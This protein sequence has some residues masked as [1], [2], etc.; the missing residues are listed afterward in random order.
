MNSDKNYSKTAFP[1][2]EPIRRT[3]TQ[4][5]ILTPPPERR[6]HPAAPVRLAGL[7]DESGVPLG[8]A[9]RLCGGVRIPRPRRCI[10][11]APLGLWCS[12]WHNVLHLQFTLYRCTKRV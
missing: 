11:P 3:E 6:I 10:L 7:P 1:C 12:C 4:G 9:T 8:M 5:R 2:R